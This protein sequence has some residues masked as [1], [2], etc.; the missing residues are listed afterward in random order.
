MFLFTLIQKYICRQV[1]LYMKKIKDLICI[2]KGRAL[3]RINTRGGFLQ[4]HIQMNKKIM[5]TQLRYIHNRVLNWKKIMIVKFPKQMKSKIKIIH[6]IVNDNKM[7]INQ[8]RKWFV[9]NFAYSV[10]FINL[11]DCTFFL[12]WIWIEMLKIQSD[13]LMFICS[14]QFQG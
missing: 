7:I 6:V 9:F 3:K 1:T 8:K 13:F 12:F 4:L 10:I 5:L 2:I 14:G 11:L